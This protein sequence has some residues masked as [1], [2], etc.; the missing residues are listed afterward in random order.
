MSWQS[1]KGF[2]LLKSDW[3]LNIAAIFLAS[4]L[5]TELVIDNF[6]LSANSTVGKEGST[7]DSSKN[8]VFSNNL[9]DGFT[10]LV[11]SISVP[12]SD[13]VFLTVSWFVKPSEFMCDL[14]VAPL[15]V[16]QVDKMSTR[17]V[18]LSEVI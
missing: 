5:E 16:M 12:F 9:L 6:S 4:V 2:V 14:P 13:G 10:F 1:C 11:L 3:D 7:D 17:I 8:N 18:L 15:G